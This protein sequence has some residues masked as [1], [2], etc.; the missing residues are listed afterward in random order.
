M[1]IEDLGS[2]NG[3]LINDQPIEDRLELESGDIVGIG[4]STLVYRSLRD[5]PTRTRQDS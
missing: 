5:A 4:P 1:I 3:T 2:K